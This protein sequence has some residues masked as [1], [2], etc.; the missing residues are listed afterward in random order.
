[1]Q[2]SFA[3]ETM[4]QLHRHNAIFILALSLSLCLMINAGVILHRPSSTDDDALAY[5]DGNG[6]LMMDA[7]DGNHLESRRAM[8]SP[9]ANPSFYDDIARQMM[10][11]QRNAKRSK[12]NLHTNLNLPRYL[13]TVD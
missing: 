1:M 6:V 8:L 11:Q 5:V 10:H 2:C 13:R 7:A 12:L 3:D 9:D 4:V